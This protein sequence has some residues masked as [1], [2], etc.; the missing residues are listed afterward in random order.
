VLKKI[1]SLQIAVL[2]IEIAI[3]MTLLNQF[4]EDLKFVHVIVGTLVALVSIATVYF[5]TREKAGRATIGLC[6]TALM[7]VILAALG[8][9]LTN[10]DYDQGLMLMR[11]SAI[12][13]L[14]LSAMCFYTARKQS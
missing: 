5:A 4:N 11:V 8:G 10:T 14:G 6:V 2:V 3:G 9:K 12:V 13:A 1:L 7:F